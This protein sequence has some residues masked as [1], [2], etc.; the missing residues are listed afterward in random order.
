MDTSAVMIDGINY[1]FANETATVARGQMTT[2]KRVVIPEKVLYN[3]K[4]Y[5]VTTLDYGAFNN[6][7]NVTHITLPETV[8]SIGE[9]C[10][11]NC[12]NLQTVDLPSGLEVLP[13]QSFQECSNLKELKLPEK[14][15]RIR[16]YV[17]DE[18]TS[19]TEITVPNEVDSIGFC[20]FYGC[21]SLSAAVIG[22]S[23]KKMG[24]YIFGNTQVKLLKVLCETP[25]DVDS[26]LALPSNAIIYVPS[27]CVE[28]YKNASVWNQYTIKGSLD[29]GL[30]P[31]LEYD[32]L[33]YNYDVDSGTY[34]VSPQSENEEGNYQVT[35]KIII[36]DKIVGAGRIYTVGGIDEN[37]FAGSTLTSILLPETIKLIDRGAFRNCRSLHTITVPDNVKTLGKEAFSGCS[38]LKEITL[39]KSIETIGNNCFYGTTLEN[40]T[41]Y[42]E[43]PPEMLSDSIDIPT[44]AKVFVPANAVSA[45][46]NN[47]QW[48]KLN[49]LPDLPHY[50][51]SLT[52]ADG[53]TYNY[54]EKSGDYLVAPQNSDETLN[55]QGIG[56]VVIPDS[57]TVADT[58]YSV[59]GF[60]KNAFAG[61]SIRS[62][63]YPEQFSEIP[64]GCFRNCPNLI[65]VRISEKTS[66]IGTEAFAGSEN[67]AE[68]Y[69][70]C[71]TPPTLTN[72]V[73]SSSIY[74]KAF[75]YVLANAENAFKQASFWSDFN[76]LVNERV[77]TVKIGQ[78]TYMLSL[79][80]LTGS[81]IAESDGELNY[82]LANQTVSIPEKVKH[83]DQEF[84]IN[85]I[86][87][88]AFQNSRIKELMIPASIERVGSSTFQGAS[89]GTIDVPS[90]DKWLELFP[91]RTSRP[92]NSNPGYLK[93]N[94]ERVT[95][96][97]ITPDLDYNPETFTGCLGITTLETAD[98][99]EILDNTYGV[100]DG[101]LT[102]LIIGK[103]VTTIST[104]VTNRMTGLCNITVYN[105]KAPS[106]DRSAFADKVY[107]RATLYLNP[108]SS[109]FD[110]YSSGWYAFKNVEYSTIHIPDYE[111]FM[112]GRSKTYGMT[113]CPSS[114]DI[115]GDIII[116]SSITY[117][118]HSITIDRATGFDYCSKIT[119][120]SFPSSLKT[121]GSISGCTLL[122]KINLSIA[123]GDDPSNVVDMM[124]L[125]G[126]GTENDGQLFEMYP[127]I[128]LYI[129]KNLLASFNSGYSMES[130]PA[131]FKGYKAL[132]SVSISSNV[133]SVAAKAFAGCSNLS[134]LMIENGFTTLEFGYGALDGTNITDLTLG[135]KT[136][137]ANFNE[138]INLSIS[139]GVNSI[140]QELFKNATNLKNVRIPS[141]VT[142][143]GN[144]A[145]SG[146]ASLENLILSPETECLEIGTSAFDGCSSIK[147]LSIPAFVVRINSQAFANCGS[148]T[149]V[150]FEPGQ[151]TLLAGN[152]I[153]ENTPLKNLN[154]E[155]EISILS[156]SHYPF[157]ATAEAFDLN[158]GC[159]VGKGLF[160]KAD[161]NKL[162]FGNH[163]TSIGDYAFY[164]CNLNKL[165][166]PASVTSIGGS[167]F[168]GCER[169][170]EIE[171]EDSSEPLSVNIGA[172]SNCAVENLYLGR[173][174]KRNYSVNYYGGVFAYNYNLKSVELGMYI[175]K[176]DN[177]EFLN[178]PN[179]YSFT[180]GVGVREIENNAVGYIPG[181]TD[182]ISNSWELNSFVNNDIP[183]IIWLPNTRPQGYENLSGRVNYVSQ[184][185]YNL[186]NQKEYRN[187]SAKFWVDGV[188]YVFNRQAA[189]RTCVAID[190]KYSPIFT[191]ME[192]PSEVEYK[193]IKFKVEEINDYA[194]Y[195][196]E[197]M[198]RIDIGNHIVG[199]GEYC[200]S[201]CRNLVSV[202]IP[203][204]VQTIDQWAF[205]RCDSLEAA[206]I[207]TGVSEIR[208]GC[209]SGDANLREFMIPS[210]V[211][212]IGNQVF[213]GCKGLKRL[214]IMDRKT[215]L[216][217]GY[218]QKIVDTC[219]NPI[220]GKPLFVDC[221]LEDVYIGGNISYSTSLEDGYSP[222]YR[223]D[224]LK[225]VT[226]FN[227][228][229]EISDNEFY[230]CRN[231]KEVYIGNSVERIG[232]FA[233]SE[234]LALEIFTIGNKV[235][236]IGKDAFSDCDKMTS[237]TS[238]SPVPPV[239]GQQAL[240]DINQ[241]NCILYV[242]AVGIDAYRHAEQWRNFFNIE[243]ITSVEIPV[244]SLSLSYTTLA[245]SVGEQ[246]QIEATVIPKNATDPHLV[247]E[248]DDN[249]VA[250]VS[251]FGNIIAIGEGSCYITVSTTDGSNISETCFVTVS[252][253]SGVLEVTVSDIRI[254]RNDSTMIISGAKDSDR[255]YIFLPNGNKVYEG[256]DK[257][258]E[259]LQHGLNIIIVNNQVFKVM[260]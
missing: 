45:Y 119:S 52:E 218:S 25:P 214:E 154:C 192:V 152:H 29:E 134:E 95:T 74:S 175:E 63:A 57:I 112:L 231:L 259:N 203:N 257:T 96:V 32:G 234:C 54:D 197:Y 85:A 145:F 247:W 162:R 217:L 236:T 86:Y 233:F 172:F 209:F 5:T 199:I 232:D 143:I 67:I 120:L 177:Y 61:S 92:F 250:M 165:E 38:A 106:L 72:G 182:V 213:D 71:L 114:K 122:K 17:F 187:L 15:K 170:S 230:G 223:N 148:L 91:T 80:Y 105:H 50:R 81:V 194:F 189:D 110:N 224:F 132:R 241:F 166:I 139:D 48:C 167:A 201:G 87:D 8:T 18:C 221:E 168:E 222:F 125:F 7:S 90:L 163:I 249:D 107:A 153:F 12:S 21:T 23:V 130:I 109:G 108:L 142:E 258:F 31:S 210:N 158:V 226:V 2:E 239:C 196:Q 111:E 124:N 246:N 252:D 123:Y 171:I 208:T 42:A 44:T 174:L 43:T 56:N 251:Q 183:K 14:L 147:A 4:E 16:S 11:A 191:D 256:Y 39:G 103:D 164:Q 102:N 37:A 176:I 186:T 77:E 138:V 33:F 76:I 40:V 193:N 10:F 118:G 215:E 151:S 242:P 184:S 75:L 69:A 126:A 207:G 22:K 30:S 104:S 59:G 28:A 206:I 133:N 79:D 212:S 94:G 113:I 190:C 115:E 58:R 129:N 117:D 1:T 99:I 219:A 84:D 127:D 140:S 253:D 181:S 248:S 53:I 6:N 73:F 93:I 180:V 3:D 24:N 216:S 146:C 65:K 237:F 62:I 200:F 228:E 128:E 135:R 229:T 9:F 205:S 60:M 159:N 100:D 244:T 157:A 204:S 141:S 136:T 88:N 121:V 131:V 144:S 137:G 225:K 13:V 20:A 47:Y 70:F 36:P 179:I 185:A 169:L 198:T 89:I 220:A 188:L 46:K 243:P 19:L 211:M 82:S 227:N 178:C 26:P 149:E 254:I 83:K 155:R 173:K 161:I 238:H 116:P 97:V 160:S 101:S 68:I 255:V 245:M 156:S 49:V 240:D 64:N 202:F 78:L 235:K 260:I 98:G 55:Y 150:T 35:G 41:I 27:G 195:N 66:I 34:F 51:F